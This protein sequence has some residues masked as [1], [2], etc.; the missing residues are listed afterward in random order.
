MSQTPPR[1]RSGCGCLGCFGRFLGFII[2][3]VI[4]FLALSAVFT[5][6]A[7]YLGGHFHPIPYWQG[8]GIIHTPAAGDYFLIV[9]MSPTSPGRLGNAYVTG[10]AW[11][12]TPHGDRLS[13]RLGG[14]MPK[15]SMVN[16]QGQPIHLYFYTRP[17]L[18]NIVPDRRP[19]FDLYGTWGDR[20]IP[21]DDHGS[22]ASAFRPDGT[23]YLGN[24]HAP[25]PAKPPVQFVL[26]ESPGMFLSPSCPANF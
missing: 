12:C 15:N 1:K 21:V 7:F 14:L 11:L 17:F 24:D 4:F 25:S 18:A 26:R 8:A 10:L 9:Q 13:L 22:L 6:W 5:P 20:Q 19:G 2:I 23:P 16:S 3:G